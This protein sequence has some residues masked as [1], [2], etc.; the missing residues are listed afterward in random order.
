MKLRFDR[1]IPVIPIT[2]FH[3]GHRVELAK[4]VLDT[5][6]ATSI[7][8]KDDLARHGIR[9]SSEDANA[10]VTGIGGKESVVV[11]RIDQIQVGDLRLNNYEIDIGDMK[12]IDDIDGLIGSDF[13]KEVGAVLDF[14]RMEIRRA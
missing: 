3:E 14:G 8:W 12:Y 5:G 9:Q 10:V 1:G 7:F 13:L 11:K 6:S 2:I 4:V